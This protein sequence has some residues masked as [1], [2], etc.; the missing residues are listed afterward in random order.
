MRLYIQNDIILSGSLHS[1]HYIFDSIHGGTIPSS[2]QKNEVIVGF[3][4]ID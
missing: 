2:N 4:G 1:I 3:M